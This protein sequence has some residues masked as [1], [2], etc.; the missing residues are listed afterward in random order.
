MFEGFADKVM[1]VKALLTMNHSRDVRTVNAGVE[2]WLNERKRAAG[3]TD[4]GGR[5]DAGG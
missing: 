3:E 4:A 5:S 1:G 2:V